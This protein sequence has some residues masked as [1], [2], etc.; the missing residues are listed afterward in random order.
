MLKKFLKIAKCCIFFGFVLMIFFTSRDSVHITPAQREAE[1]YTYDLVS[2]H[3]SNIMDKWFNLAYDY[4]PWVNQSTEE[5]LG[6]LELYFNLGAEMDQ[7]QK[8]QS[9]EISVN[10][11]IVLSSKIENI[12][13]QRNTLLDDVEEIIEATISSVVVKEGLGIWNNIV[14]PPVDIRLTSTPKLLI[15]SPRNRIE[16]LQDVLI[17]PE[18]KLS[19]RQRVENRLLAESNLSA[20]IIDIGGVATY[21]ASIPDNKPLRWTLQIAAHEWL[22][23]WF[24]FQPLGQHMFD[25]SAMQMLNETAANIAGNEL[26]EIAF[27]SIAREILLIPYSN[28]YRNSHTS[29]FDFNKEMK[30]TRLRLDEILL[31]GDV[32]AAETY[33]H[34]RR[35]VFVDNHYDIR[36]LNQAYFAFYGTYADN[37]ASVSPIG[38]QMNRFRDL[39]PSLGHFIKDISD[40]SSYEDFLHKLE[41]REVT[42]K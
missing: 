14:I 33:L 38:I 24:F 7:L 12:E 9:S 6:K 36:K 21:P 1:L 11:D 26:G 4:M 32:Q 19:E 28:E 34:D 2:W 23:H 25:D 42:I 35:Q 3:L 16:R 27:E 17:D 40:V 15:T 30:E 39:A 22:H 41:A 37:A 29:L 31:T 8:A 13:I 20:I 10:K 18:I 5:R